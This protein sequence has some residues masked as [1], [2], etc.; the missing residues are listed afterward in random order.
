MSLILELRKGKL[1]GDEATQTMHEYCYV[2]SLPYG[3]ATYVR[4]IYSPRTLDGHL[5][6]ATP[7]PNTIPCTVRENT[8][9][10]NTL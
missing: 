10:E 2:A 5:A 3:S 4:Y 1:I 7:N 8:L 9:R 6:D